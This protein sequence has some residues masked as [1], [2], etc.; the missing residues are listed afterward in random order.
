MKYAEVAVDAPIGINRTLTYAVPPSVQPIP[1]Q[2]VW[3]PLGQRPVQGVVFKVTNLP[4]VEFPR[5]IISTIEPA[6]MV[7]SVGLDLARWISRYY[8]SSLFDAVSLM[9]PPGF[10]DRVTP[11]LE[12][13]DSDR[14]PGLL[15]NE[16]LAVWQ[17]FLS[18]RSVPEADVKKALGR[19]GGS[20][21]IRLVRR[22]LLRRTW[23]LPR[24][25]TSLRY[26]AYIR[27]NLQDNKYGQLEKLFPSRA[28]RQMALAKALLESPQRMCL[29]MARKQFGASA[30]RGLMNKGLLVEEWVRKEAPSLDCRI[31][32]EKSSITLTPEQ[33]VAVARINVVQAKKAKG[34]VFLVHGVTGSGKTEVYL[35]ALEQCVTLGRIGIMLVPEIS[36][37]PQMVG[38][39]NARFPGRVA[40]MHSGLSLSEQFHYWWRIRDGAY[41]VVVGPRSALFSPLP[42]LGLIIMDEEHEWTYKE[43]ERTPRYHARDVAL[44]LSQISDVPLVMGSATP[45]VI[46]YH[47]ALRNRYQL[48][49]LPYRIL[50]DSAHFRNRNNTV[51]L[52]S[53]EVQ[54]MRQEL[55]EGNRSPLSRV[56]AQALQR[57][58]EKGEQAILFLN[59]RGTATLVQCRACGL[60][61]RCRRCAISLTYHKA[62]GLLCHYCNRQERTPIA[63]PGCRSP[64]IRFLG[65]G[66]QRVVEELERLI[67]T[68][69]VMRWDRDA[70]VQSGGHQSLMEAFSRGHAQVLIGTQMIAKGLH[71]PNVSL[72]GVVLAD[73]GLHLPDFRAGERTFQLLC[74]VAGRAGRGKT[75]GKVVIQTYNPENYAIQ[76]AAQQ[77]YMGFYQK[78]LEY[79]K[80]QSNPPFSRLVHMTYL[81][82]NE[83]KCRR[84]AMRLGQ[85][86]RSFAYGH[87]LA[88]VSVI[89]AAPAYPQRVK[90][91]FRW[92]IILRCR[93]PHTILENVTIPKGWILDVDPVTI[94]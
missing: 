9:L 57:C 40:M 81:H 4:Q 15:N 5:E 48:L 47:R 90:G 21:S 43:Q 13:V 61:L 10:R 36:L 2:M 92:H 25:R 1:G 50:P 75:P 42:K 93:N 56:L 94:L 65:L 74:Q 38:L 62:R 6:S 51:G 37:T 14:D 22:G 88:D 35:R 3:V 58:V 32:G 55:K 20:S 72:V 80:E 69:S 91:R 23:R 83:D 33:S 46:T 79:R 85:T 19:S 29:T 27:P 31:V 11:Y 30:V 24:S 12:L 54:D 73:I 76:S 59:R 18:Y 84:E 68:I 82:S 66:T 17:H 16:D 77:D 60:I 78:E 49:E 26:D 63:C 34:N 67:P 71:V 86:L 89:G 87:G 41:D 53:V 45:D 70:V 64:L 8:L 7:S 39:L 44:K 52:A 28:P